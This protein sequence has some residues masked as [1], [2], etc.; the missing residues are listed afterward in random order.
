MKLSKEV[1]EA[2]EAVV[3]KLVSTYPDF[4]G[5][6]I[7]T[8]LK[9]FYGHQMRRARLYDIR[10]RALHHLARQRGRGW[11]VVNGK[12]KNTQEQ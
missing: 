4:T 3:W 5:A 7:Q 6:Q 9:T 2:R 11:V 8:H 10:S 12:L 1:I